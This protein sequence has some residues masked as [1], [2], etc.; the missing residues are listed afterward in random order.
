MKSLRTNLP[1]LA[2]GENLSYLEMNLNQVFPSEH[3]GYWQ[4]R[5]LKVR[6]DHHEASRTATYPP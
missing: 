2:G 4:G 5:L 3:S 1:N 6:F